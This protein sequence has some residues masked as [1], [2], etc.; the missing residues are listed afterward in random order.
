M[1][2][3]EAVSERAKND[4]KNVSAIAILTMKEATRSTSAGDVPSR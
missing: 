1:G 3:P 2:V 4:G